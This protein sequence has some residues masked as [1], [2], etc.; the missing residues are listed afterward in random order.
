M[1]VQER[2]G[3]GPKNKRLDVIMDNT[4]TAG[5]CLSDVGYCDGFSRVADS[6]MIADEA[7]EN[8]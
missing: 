3:K 1:D 6:R 8:F 7:K 2:R 5:V 4:K